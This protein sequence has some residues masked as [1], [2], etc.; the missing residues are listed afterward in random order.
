MCSLGQMAQYAREE[1]FK[2]FWRSIKDLYTVAKLSHSG[3]LVADAAKEE[4]T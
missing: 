2:I 1:E 3:H 4:E